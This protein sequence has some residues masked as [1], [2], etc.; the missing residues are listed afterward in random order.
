M[1]NFYVLIDEDAKKFLDNL[2]KKSHGLVKTKLRIL[3]TDPFSGKGGDKEL[4]N[5][6]KH[7][8]VYRLHISRSYTAFYRISSKEKTVKILWHGTIGHA[9]NKYG[10]F[11]KRSTALP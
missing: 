7:E 9:H 5:S 8:D 3:E 6:P 4:L 1:V 11:A 10:R 2:P